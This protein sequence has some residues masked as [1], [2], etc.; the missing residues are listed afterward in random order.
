M[1]GELR[2]SV[3][4]VPVDA[5]RFVSTVRDGVRWVYAFSDEA[6]LARFAVALGYPG[7]ESGGGAAQ[8]SRQEW[9]FVS[10][11]GAR[12]LDVV[13]PSL[14]GPAGVAV[15]VADEERSMLFPPV[16]GIVPDTIAVDAVDAS[17][18]RR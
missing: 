8:Q 16:R 10:V 15:D 5:G 6:A 11:L 4:L 18:V 9:E 17:E 2:R 3:L 14:D 12:L 13:L 7:A 1:V